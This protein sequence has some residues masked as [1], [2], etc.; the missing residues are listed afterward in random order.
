[1][2]NEDILFQLKSRPKPPRNKNKLN[3]ATNKT[4]FGN[5]LLIHGLTNK[6]PQKPLGKLLIS[7]IISNL[8]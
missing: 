3:A 7:K 4:M 5:M 6:K 2:V 8:G 1:M